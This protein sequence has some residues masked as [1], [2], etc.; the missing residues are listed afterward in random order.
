M[1]QPHGASAT[2]YVTYGPFGL[3]VRLGSDNIN[4][5]AHRDWGGF[6]YAMSVAESYAPFA[7]SSSKMY[8]A[9]EVRPWGW[10][11]PWEEIAAGMQLGEQLLRNIASQVLIPH[12]FVFKL[13]KVH[14]L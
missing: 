11:I 13:D 14:T 3:Y 2:S 9:F 6:Y 5:Y 10:P 1:V 8:T 4:G 7:M 12:E